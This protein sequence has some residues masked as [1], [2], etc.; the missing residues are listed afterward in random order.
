MDNVFDVNG[1]FDDEMGAAMPSPGPAGE[2]A[3]D[4]F[5]ADVHSE[6]LFKDAYTDL[7]MPADSPVPVEAAVPEGNQ[8][9]EDAVRILRKDKTLRQITASLS[10]GDKVTFN[11]LNQKLEEAAAENDADH[12]APPKPAAAQNAAA[13]FMDLLMLQKENKVLMRQDQDTMRK[14][15][16]DEKKMLSAEIEV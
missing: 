8:Q 6:A 9:E 14:H 11:N 7:D 13:L 15:K 12:Q 5:A 16:F 10:N 1:L 2:V 3:D 4:A